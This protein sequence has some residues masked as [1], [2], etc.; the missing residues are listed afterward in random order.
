ME[1]AYAAGQS[2]VFL[3]VIDGKF[4]R[5]ALSWEAASKGLKDPEVQVVSSDKDLFRNYVRAEQILKK[6]LQSVSSMSVAD[7]L[8]AARKDL[9][10]ETA[11]GATP[12]AKSK[13]IPARASES[14]PSGK[15]V[16]MTGVMRTR[17]VAKI[18][19]LFVDAE[20]AIEVKHA[21]HEPEDKWLTKTMV[22]PGTVTYLSDD[23]HK[24]ETGSRL[25][26]TIDDF[27]AYKKNA[28]SSFK[29]MGFTEFL[30]FCRTASDVCANSSKPIATANIPVF[31]E[32]IDI[33]I[34][35][36]ERM[37]MLGTLGKNNMRLKTLLYLHLMVAVNQGV[38][39]V[40]SNALRVFREN[41]DIFGRSKVPGY[42]TQSTHAAKKH[43]A[44][45]VIQ[46]A[47]PFAGPGRL[48]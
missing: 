41:V 2:R 30:A 26:T 18:K 10:G 36:C 11:S 25:Q 43:V 12:V 27:W 7:K 15:R 42:P 31:V 22:A 44:R 38:L 40:G 8:A 28:V 9:A 20:K 24:Y 32:L 48:I 16:G 13:A 33:A 19:R 39:F 3:C 23:V 6:R 34:K 37:T 14:L 5:I 17:E 1:A 21:P 47:S 4:G 35:E 45:P 46:Q 29:L